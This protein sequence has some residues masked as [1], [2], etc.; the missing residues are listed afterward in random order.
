[1][2]LTPQEVNARASQAMSLL[3]SGRAG[4]AATTFSTIIRDGYQDKDIWLGLAIASQA[5]RDADLMMNALDHVL[6]EDPTNLRALI[7]KGD[8]LWSQ[9][10]HSSAAMLFNYIRKLVPD[11]EGLPDAARP[12]VERIF[13]RLAQHNQD[14]RSHVDTAL[15]VDHDVEPSASDRA[16]FEH[17]RDLLFAKRQRFIQEPRAFYYPELPAQQ[18]YETDAFDWT[19]KLLAAEDQIRAEFSALLNTPNLFTPYIHASGNVPVNRNHPLLDNPDWSAVHLIKNGVMEDSVCSLMPS[20]LTAL[21][22]APLERIEGR[23][24]T[25]LV[26]RLA[27]GAKIAAHTGYLNTRLTC[28]LPLVI[29]DG[30]GLRCGNETRH[31]KSGEMLIFNDSIDHEAW[32]TSS[33]DRYVII[34]FVWRPELSLAERGLIKGLLE[35]VDAYT[36]D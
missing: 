15:S 19:A 21:E 25:V 24:P 18:F 10:D 35:S 7:M 28:H 23:G 36:P 14:V 27:A 8:Q 9:G 11:P 20:V 4:E 34:F 26:S 22:D 2:T 13:A 1:M 3:Q 12:Q 33:E 5:G 30:C 31:W 17:A 32:N 6:E 16:R 29:P